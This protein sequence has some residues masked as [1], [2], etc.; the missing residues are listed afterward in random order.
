[1]IFFN[2]GLLPFLPYQLIPIQVTTLIFASFEKSSKESWVLLD[3]FKKSQNVFMKLANSVPF[4]YF[5]TD[6]HGKALAQNNQADILIDPNQKSRCFQDIVH[7]H[8][9]EKISKSIKEAVQKGKA[10]IEVPLQNTR[11]EKL[12]KNSTNF[13]KAEKIGTINGFDFYSLTIEK[14]A[15][16]NANCLRIVCENIDIYK[17]SQ[18][19]LMKNANLMRKELKTLCEKLENSIRKPE[20]KESEVDLLCEAKQIFYHNE[21]SLLATSMFLKEYQPEVENFNIADCLSIFMD[22]HY[23]QAISKGVQIVLNIEASF[24]KEVS[25]EKQKFEMVLSAI[26]SFLIENSEKGQ[27]ITLKANWKQHIEGGFKLSFE[28]EYQANEYTSLES[29]RSALGCELNTLETLR[30][31]KNLLE[32]YGFNLYQSASIIKW[33]GGKVEVRREIMG[34]RVELLLIFRFRMSTNQRYYMNKSH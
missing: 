30:E 15:W 16:K 10:N 23:K 26:F 8:Y 34:K 33:L 28:L 4:P 19:V 22:L 2:N 25:G 21:H 12:E 14:I 5:I 27:E 18:E 31:K 3:S 20:R 24:P 1:M 32:K 7:P 11:S 29:M 9:K 17:L 13:M 6:L